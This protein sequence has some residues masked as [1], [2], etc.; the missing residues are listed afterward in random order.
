M[1][2]APPM[3]AA[4][5][6]YIHHIWFRSKFKFKTNEIIYCSATSVDGSLA[7]TGGEKYVIP[8]RTLLLVYALCTEKSGFLKVWD[9]IGGKQVSAI[10]IG[11]PIL[12]IAVVNLSK[13]WDTFFVG[14][15]DG[16]LH[17]YWRPTT[18]YKFHLLRIIGF[19]SVRVVLLSDK[20][21]LPGRIKSITYLKPI[22]AVASQN[23]Y[24]YSLDSC[25]TGILPSSIRYK[26]K[27]INKQR[28][29]PHELVTRDSD[30]Y[31]NFVYLLHNNLLL[32]MFVDC[33]P[34]GV[35]TIIGTLA[36]NPT[37][38]TLAINN[39]CDGVDILSIPHLTY[40]GTIP[41]KVDPSHNFIQG[42]TFLSQTCL[43]IGES[44]A[45]CVGDITTLQT[46]FSLPGGEIHNI[47]RSITYIPESQTLVA[48]S[49]NGIIYLW[50][51]KDRRA[52]RYQDA[53]NSTSSFDPVVPS[54]FTHRHDIGT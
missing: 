5:A 16:L 45:I 36:V 39:L 43:I 33:I 46:V 21:I 47:F 38:N 22:V 52:L 20:D 41:K 51:W 9:V 54:H 32:V 7:L 10:S 4:E 49:S 35:E 18:S 50:D 48:V 1:S 2:F 14:C 44:S 53:C 19:P 28:L 17:L 37:C 12:Q 34:S 30:W 24:I 40:L 23:L 15:E 6:S 11:S 25:W 26:L 31:P 13:R 29:L 3:S 8:T 27:L 42:L